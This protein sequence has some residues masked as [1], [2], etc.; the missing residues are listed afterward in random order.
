MCSSKKE[1]ESA[2]KI[3]HVE[4]FESQFIPARNLDIWLPKDYSS[5]KKYNVLYMHDG[6]MLFDSTTT[7]NGQSWNAGET[8]QK[9]IDAKK[10]KETIIVGIHNIAELRIIEYFPRKAFDLLEQE[11]VDSLSQG[12]LKQKPESDNY[13]KFIVQELKPYID[14]VYSTKP[15]RENTFVAGSS[16][17]GLISMYAICE[18]PDVFGGAA[19]LSTH[20]PGTFESNMEIPSAFK[21]YV[22]ANLPSPANHKIYFDYGTETLDQLYKPYQLMIDEVMKDKGYASENWISKEFVGAAHKETDWAK[23]LHIPLEFVLE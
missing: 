12:R 6:Q 3:V 17:G 20:W 5:K 4:M 22:A 10:V 8:M 7:W 21:A 2:A 11:V 15:G 13:L 18:Y 23:R 16:M 14:S 19:C 1:V 9:M